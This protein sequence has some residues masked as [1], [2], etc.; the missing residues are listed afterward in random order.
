MKNKKIIIVLLMILF[1][2]TGCTKQLKNEKGEV[3]KNPDTGQVLPSNIIC[4]PTD[5]DNIKLYNETNEKLIEKYKKELEDGDISKKE[6]KKKVNNLT[7]IDELVDCKKFTPAS[8]GYDGLWSTFFVK[9]LSWILIQIGNI[10]KNYGLSIIIATIL[11]RLALYPITVKTARQ[12]ESLKEAKPELDKL[13]KKYANKTDQ[14]SM[15]KKS[16]EMMLI[17]KKYNINPLS[18]CLFAFL[19]IPLF[20]AFYEALNRLPILFED[21]LIF[22]M[23]MTPFNGMSHGNY[24]YLI[25]PILVALTTYFSFKLNKG[26]G[27]GGQQEKQMNTMMMVMMFMIVFMS[28]TMSTAIVFYWITNSA[29]TIIQNLLVKIKRSK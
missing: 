11:I 22:E 6:Y 14:D 13:E 29:F 3:V 2:S 20:L 5:K 27:M 26:A 17:Y 18:G 21:K 16:Q 28:F 4:A 8:N 25:L 23:S 1:L 7:N 15:M 9:T 24:L 10:C 19:Q 12:S